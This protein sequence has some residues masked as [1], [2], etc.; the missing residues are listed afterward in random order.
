MRLYAFATVNSRQHPLMGLLAS[1]IRT[2]LGN[3]RL[4]VGAFKVMTDGSL[5]R[6]HRGHPRALSPPTAT[7]P[8]SSTG[9]QADLDEPARPRPPRQASSAPCTRWAIA[10]SSRR[11]TR[12]RARSARRR[13]RAAPPHRALRHLPARSAR[14]RPRAADRARSC[15]RRSSGSSATAISATTGGAR[16]HHVPGQQP[17]RGR[18]AGGGQLGRAGDALRAA[19]RDRAGADPG[20]HGRRR[21][22]P[23]RARG[24]RHRH[25]DA[26][27]QRSVRGLR[28]GARR[29]VSSRASSPI[30][31]CSARISPACPPPASAMSR[32]R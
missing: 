5:E 25:P 21:V 1:G 9:A 4:Q 10:P 24:S 32:S 14:P 12:W 16:R 30:W 7:T 27:A 2:G 20:H 13:G 3:E 18:R 11:W 15:S 26:H 17:H 29:A 8:A 28:G 23:G 6:A 22:R 31:R 19:V